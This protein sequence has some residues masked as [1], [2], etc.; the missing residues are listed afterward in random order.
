MMVIFSDFSLSY[1][2]RDSCE[3]SPIESDIDLDSAYLKHSEPVLRIRMSV[4]KNNSLPDWD[5]ITIS[6]VA[7]TQTNGISIANALI[8]QV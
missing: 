3:Y 7:R 5:V 2:R 1:F 8:S 4:Y 6:D